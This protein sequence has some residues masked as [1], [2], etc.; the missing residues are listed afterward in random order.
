MKHARKFFVSAVVAAPVLMLSACATNFD[1]DGVA[2]MPDK[3]DAFATALHKR[4]IERAKFEVGEEDWMSVDYFTGRA[5][6]AALGSAPPLQKPDERRLKKDADLIQAAYGQLSAALGTNAPKVAPDA[7]A[8]SQTW[9]EHWMEQAEE[10]HQD[11]HIAWT[12]GEYEKIVPQ[13]VGKPMAKKKP[14]KKKAMPMPGPFMIYFDHDSSMLDAEAKAA[15]AKAAAAAKMHSPQYVFVHGH[16]DTS[17]SPAYNEALAK[18][19]AHK[20]AEALKAAGVTTNVVP[21]AHNEYK[22]A[23]N[24]GDN[25]KERMNRRVEVIFGK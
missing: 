24:K 13:C 15:V 7:C 20:V 23:V 1:V 21:A 8:L 4:Y 14:M 3:G 16:T 9:L 2:A 17:G 5:E 11:D 25:V 22:P 19:R 12:R 6:M 18:K 10:G